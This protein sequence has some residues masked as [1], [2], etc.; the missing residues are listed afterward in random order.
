MLQF[1][2]NEFGLTY[3]TIDV[4]RFHFNM[5][6]SLFCFMGDV[7][8]LFKDVWWSFWLWNGRWVLNCA[9]QPS[10]DFRRSIT[11]QSSSRN[12]CRV[13]SS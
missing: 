10:V 5:F 12:S 7:C 4:F 2:S 11:S 1:I 13:G 9:F 8:W 6:F 3:F